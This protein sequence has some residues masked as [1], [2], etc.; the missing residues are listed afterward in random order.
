MARVKAGSLRLQE[1]AELLELSYRQAKR[2]WARYRGGGAR[3]LQHGNCGRRSN[4][5]HAAE[6]RAAVLERVRERYADFGAT[7][8]AEHL[9]SDD[10]LKIHAESLRRWMREAGLWQRR[11]KRKPYR[12]RRERKAHRGELVQLDGSFHRW[13]EERAGEGCLMHMV[14]DASSTMHCQFSEEETIW[15]AARLLR[16]WIEVHGVPR[17][18]YTDWK[19]VYVRAATER[20][21]REGAVPVTQFGRM[22]QKLGIRIIAASSP[23]AKGRVERNHGTH[24][25]RLIKKLRLRGIASYAEAN[26]FLEEHYIAEHNRR[27][28]RAA[29]EPAD[30][31]RRRP[32]VRQLDEV[33]W[34]EEERVVSEDWVVRY[35][36]RLLQLERQSRHWAP[37][38][39]RVVVRENEAG[40]IAIHY[41]GQRLGF[42]ELVRASTERSEERGAAPS[43]AP[44]SP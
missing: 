22:C 21:Q 8:A 38:R 29:T 36:N 39:S 14:D 4:R 30:Y 9:A 7:L 44:P 34:L 28:A 27:F 32:T 37:S 25:D 11:R 5:A 19:N 24:Q 13:L 3:A 40:A 20:E 35:N 31:H 1:A 42:R 41:R 12:Q 17:A 10:G 18:L 2:V 23:Q 16:R 43:S 6:F 33:F 26:R 15:A